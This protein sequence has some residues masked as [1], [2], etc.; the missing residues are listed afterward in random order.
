MSPTVVDSSAWV[1]FLRGDG[2][3]VSRVSRLLAAGRAALTGPIAAEVLSGA[4]SSAEFERLKRVFGGVEWMPDPASL[5]Q[6]VT[7][8]RFAL[9][10]GGFRAGIVDLAVAVTALD[11]G[12]PVLT[13]D[14][15]FDR[16]R[17]VVPIE[18]DLF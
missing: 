4:S 6:R 3:A 2:K 14:R 7:D 5:W 15:G 8:Y 13:R 12:R 1:D 9:A 17:V 10:R 16:I 18:L 11:A